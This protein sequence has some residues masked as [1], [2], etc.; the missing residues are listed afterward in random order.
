M[1]PGISVFDQNAREYDQWFDAHAD[2]YRAEA[3]A[4]RQLLPTLA[5]K[6]EI[7]GGSGRFAQA[8]GI[9]LVAE[10]SLEMGRLARGRGLQV[11]QAVGERLPFQDECFAA[12]LLVTVICFVQDVQLLLTEAAQVIRPG[13]SL[14][15]GFI[16]RESE[17][18]QLYEARKTGDRFY[19]EA[20]FYSTDQ[21]AAMV[22]GAGLRDLR[23]RQ[24]ILP[25]SGAAA[26]AV[27]EG[28]GRGSFVAIGAVKENRSKVLPA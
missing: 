17:L 16:A 25:L 13:G 5:P 11:V 14:V 6:L 28:Y 8:L 3:E 21:V 1:L 20:R 26:L 19:S 2:I 22:L 12:A 10:P 24:T 27:E 7:G 23:F 15:L 4:L 18:G 9:D